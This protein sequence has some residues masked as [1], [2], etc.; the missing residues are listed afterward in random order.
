MSEYEDKMNALALK[1]LAVALEGEPTPEPAILVTYSELA[2]AAVDDA[3]T[4]AAMGVG[5]LAAS[6]GPIGM[7]ARVERFKSIVAELEAKQR[8][9]WDNGGGIAVL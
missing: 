3:S 5:L 8:S 2:R 6:P 9:F 7:D 4:D 1:L